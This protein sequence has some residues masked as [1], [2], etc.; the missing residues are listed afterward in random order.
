MSVRG[1]VAVLCAAAVLSGCTDSEPSARPTAPTTTPTSPAPSLGPLGQP[2]CKPAS[3][4][5]SME[6]QGTP[7]ESG[8]SLYGLA[9]LR[10][11]EPLR[12]GVDIKIAWRMTGKGDLNV[13]LI[14][15][16]GHPKALAWGPEAHGGS[17]YHRPG[18]EWGTGFELDQPGCWEIRMSRDASHASVWID[19]KR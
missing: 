3:P 12:V 15:P 1:G 10:R 14:D 16:D 6:L 17:N 18:D 9:F 4:F 11:D 5:S 13:D 8:T 2:G 7:G 19:A